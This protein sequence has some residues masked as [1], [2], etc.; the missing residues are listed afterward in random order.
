MGRLGAHPH[1]V[2]VFDLGDE[3]PPL[4][5]G[6]DAIAGPREHELLRQPFIV[7]E[8]MGGGEVERSLDVAIRVC[9]GLEFAH[10]QGIVHRDLKPG[11]VWLTAAGTAKIGDFG[12]AVAIG[13][14]RFNVRRAWV[15]TASICHPSTSRAVS[16][17]HSCRNHSSTV[18]SARQASPRNEPVAIGVVGAC[19]IPL[20]C[21]SAAV[22]N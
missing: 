4:A 17:G 11:N 1:I 7:T 18:P 9:R 21:A 5:G 16:E 3:S 2:S 22:N 19:R 15:G 13:R 10:S 8:L 12:L 6:Q 20:A 14:S